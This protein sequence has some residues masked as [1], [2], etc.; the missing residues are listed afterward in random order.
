MTTALPPLSEWETLLVLA[1]RTTAYAPVF[2]DW[3]WHVG[4]PMVAYASIFVAGVLMAR[5]PEPAVHLVGAISILLLFIGIHNAWD[6]AVCVSTA[7]KDQ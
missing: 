5:R 7:R 6:A 1:R 2:E 4:L 3:L